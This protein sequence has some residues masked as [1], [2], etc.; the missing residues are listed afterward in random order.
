MEI[1]ELQNAICKLSGWFNSRL[2]MAKD[3]IS[4]L[5]DKIEET[6]HAEAQRNKKIE[7]TEKRK[8]DIEDMIRY[9]TYNWCARRK[10]K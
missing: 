8:R 6:T 2:E 3:R 10:K 1:L 4:K 9:T 7:N 5:E